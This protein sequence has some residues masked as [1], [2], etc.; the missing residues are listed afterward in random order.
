M[1]GS[2]LNLGNHTTLDGKPMYIFNQKTKK[3][4][5]EG[6]KKNQEKKKGKMKKTPSPTFFVVKQ[7]HKKST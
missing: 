4:D 7:Q 2:N 1:A 3:V 6:K 5:T